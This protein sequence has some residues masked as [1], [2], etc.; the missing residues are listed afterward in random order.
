MGGNTAI[1]RLLFTSESSTLA[2]KEFV[3]EY[4]QQT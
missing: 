4:S 3:A 2:N 1:R